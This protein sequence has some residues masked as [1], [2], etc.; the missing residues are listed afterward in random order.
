M[1]PTAVAQ[2]ATEFLVRSVETSGETIWDRPADISATES[3]G[4]GRNLLAML[5]RDVGEPPGDGDDASTARTAPIQTAWA[6]IQVEFALDT[7]VRAPTD[8]EAQAELGAA[9]RTLLGADPDLLAQVHGLLESAAAAVAAA[10]DTVARLRL[11]VVTDPAQYLPHLAGALN[12][13][14]AAYGRVGRYDEAAPLFEESVALFRQVLDDG[15]SE[16]LRDKATALDGLGWLY[17][18]VG[19][20][21]EAVSPVEEATVILRRLSSTIRPRIRP[22]SVWV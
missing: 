9:V 19:R 16:H 20:W 18:R 4:V 15:G 7:L 8:E 22:T 14:G 3:A 17:S 21:Q 12:N 6:R 11:W 13:L 10:E 1:D 5:L 2:D